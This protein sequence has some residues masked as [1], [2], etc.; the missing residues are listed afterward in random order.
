MKMN[1]ALHLL[2]LLLFIINNCCTHAAY[3]NATRCPEL[4]GKIYENKCYFV[5]KNFKSS[6]CGCQ[7]YCNEHGNGTLV[8]VKSKEHMTWINEN[9]P[10]KREDDEHESSTWRYIG[11]YKTEPTTQKDPS[12]FSQ[13]SMSCA[14]SNMYLGGFIGD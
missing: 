11:L 13:T 2:V 12:K 1:I 8:C 7:E 14:N 6:Q 10:V 3:N 5:S 9:F 4:D